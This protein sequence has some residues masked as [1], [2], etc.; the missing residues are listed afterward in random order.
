MQSK[1]AIAIVHGMVGMRGVQSLYVCYLE[2]GRWMYSEVRIYSV[3]S[4]VCTM[5]LYFNGTFKRLRLA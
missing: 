2:L 5:R 4:P 3:L 1:N